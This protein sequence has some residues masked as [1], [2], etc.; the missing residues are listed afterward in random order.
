M[1]TVTPRICLTIGTSL[2]ASFA[3]LNAIEAPLKATD[4]HNVGFRGSVTLSITVQV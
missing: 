2:V 4:A 1:L 3:I